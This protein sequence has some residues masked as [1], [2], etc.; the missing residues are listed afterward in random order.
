MATFNTIPAIPPPSAH[1]DAMAMNHNSGQHDLGMQPFDQ[2]LN[3][4]E[5]LL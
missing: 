2:E 5:A 3:F 1:N 4:D